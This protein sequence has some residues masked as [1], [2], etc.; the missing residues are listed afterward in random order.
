MSLSH[1]VATVI[2]VNFIARNQFSV[3]ACNF[4]NLFEPKNSNHNLTDFL[5]TSDFESFLNLTKQSKYLNLI[6]SF[7]KLNNL[8][9]NTTIHELCGMNTVSC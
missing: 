3:N 4:E 6:D 8:Q 1:I 7:S 2:I 5:A 9:L